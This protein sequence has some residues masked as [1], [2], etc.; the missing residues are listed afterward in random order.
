MLNDRL[1]D[2]LRPKEFLED[3]SA[4][5]DLEAI[6]RHRE[7]RRAHKKRDDAEN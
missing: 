4:D 7:A 2:K 6:M 3:E 1:M 5:L